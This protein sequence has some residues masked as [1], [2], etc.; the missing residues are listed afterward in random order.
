MPFNAMDLFKVGSSLGQAQAGPASYAT[1]N[2]MDVFKKKQELDYE[3]KKSYGLLNYKE[4]L[5]RSRPSE[6]ARTSL[7]IART[8]RLTGS[9]RDVDAQ[10]IGDAIISGDQ[11]PDLQRLYGK[12]AS[13]KSYLADKGFNL[14]K[15]QA[16]WTSTSQFAKSLNGPQQLR[17]N[18][19]LN[20]VE[21]SL[22]ILQDISEHFKRT[23]WTPAN[24]VE[25]K[26][27]MSGTDPTKRD[28]ATKYITQMN[29]MKDELAQ[30]FMS[31]GVPT[32]G[33]FKMADDI[34]NPVYGVNQLDA[35]IQQLG[36]NLKVRRNAIS[37]S[38]PSLVGGLSNPSSFVGK[39]GV[40]ENQGNAFTQATR[41]GQKPDTKVSSKGFK[42]SI[43]R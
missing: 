42:Y 21:S 14:S 6:V 13:I 11:P 38:S 31:G 39:L 41:I 4:G 10:K 5:E 15:A 19:A 29:V 2:V 25:L 33:A 34:L 28:I 22:P 12:A 32:D 30:A 23:G 3:M 36:L 35:G 37:N 9:G 40:G 20:S 7:E 17:L 24:N 26:L 8:N 1:E 43:T 18:Q 16:D 27:A